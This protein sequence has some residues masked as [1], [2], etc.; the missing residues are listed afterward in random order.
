MDFNNVL[1]NSVQAQL[2][3]QLVMSCTAANL[4]QL[5][6]LITVLALQL[7]MSLSDIIHV[8]QLCDIQL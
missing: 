1:H 7:L 4:Y 2:L 3:L 5:H 6:N 8:T